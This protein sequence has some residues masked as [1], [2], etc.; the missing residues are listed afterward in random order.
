MTCFFATLQ[1]IECSSFATCLYIHRVK[2]VLSEQKV[3]NLILTTWDRLLFWM[4]K[5]E[6]CLQVWDNIHYDHNFDDSFCYNTRTDF[7]QKSFQNRGINFECLCFIN[8]NFILNLLCI[9]WMV[10]TKPYWD[11]A[12]QK[13][14]WSNFECL[15]FNNCYL[16]LSKL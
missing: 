10:A 5:S 13:Q 2:L 14:N 11:G 15:C 3:N 16:T 8:W 7:V 12:F 1:S 4:S 6:L 9:S